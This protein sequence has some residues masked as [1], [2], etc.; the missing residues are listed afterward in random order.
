MRTTEGKRDGHGAANQEQLSPAVAR[1][2]PKDTHKCAYITVEPR[3]RAFYASS[4]RF[5]WV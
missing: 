3:F 1:S 2:S 4:R 5:Y